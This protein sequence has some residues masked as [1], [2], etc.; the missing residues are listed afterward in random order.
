MAAKKH[1]P[2]PAPPERHPGEETYWASFAIWCVRREILRLALL[3]WIT[4]FWAARTS[5]GSACFNATSADPRSPEAI[6][7]STLRTAVRIRVRRDLLIWVRRAILRVAFLAEVV[8]AI[9]LSC[10]KPRQWW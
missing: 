6:A 1:P 10:L 8:L 7:S 4:P 3:R 9:V 2:I 5:S